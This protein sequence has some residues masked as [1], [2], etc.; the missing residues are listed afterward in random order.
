M[1]DCCRPILPLGR[2]EDTC[3]EEW[4]DEKVCLDFHFFETAEMKTYLRTAGFEVEEAIERDPYPEIEVQTR[5]AYLFA[6]KP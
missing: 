1:V 3:V 5:R 2:Q 4:F 6:K